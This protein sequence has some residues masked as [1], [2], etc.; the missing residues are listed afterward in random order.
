[1]R[2]EVGAAPA[3][4]P[5]I[6]P[7]PVAPA[8]MPV[9][10]SCRPARC[11]SRAGRTAESRKSV[12]RVLRELV[13]DEVEDAAVLRHV[14][15]PCRARRSTSVPG[16]MLLQVPSCGG[17]P[18]RAEAPELHS[19]AVPI[20]LPNL[21]NGPVRD[22]ASLDEHRAAR[23]RAVGD[24]RRSSRGSR[25]SAM[26]R[27]RLGPPPGATAVIAPANPAIATR[28][29]SAASTA[30]HI[31]SSPRF[32]WSARVDRASVQPIEDPSAT[33]VK[34]RRRGSAADA[35]CARREPHRSLNGRLDP[36][37]DRRSGTQGPRSRGKGLSCRRSR[38]TRGW[39]NGHSIR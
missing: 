2:R 9:D 10:R 28:A 7:W 36:S 21:P 11:R 19:A 14:R 8:K 20:A 5:E 3:P 38:R 31:P 25:T 23:R 34:K 37:A 35:R 26:D 17:G 39:C 18:D 1:M 22:A 16:G 29:R 15:R 6:E 24:C 27:R 4:S 12:E 30:C 13:V 33:D 32:Q